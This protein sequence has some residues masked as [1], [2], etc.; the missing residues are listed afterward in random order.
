MLKKISL[1]LVKSINRANII[2]VN[3]LIICLVALAIGE[4][5]KVSIVTISNC[6]P[7]KIGSGSRLINPKFMLKIASMIM[8]L[9]QPSD[10]DPAIACRM[11]IGPIRP[12]FFHLY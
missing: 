4:P 5:F 10:A 2:Q 12:Y 11:P 1:A 6:P 3:E 7:S 8:R 9:C